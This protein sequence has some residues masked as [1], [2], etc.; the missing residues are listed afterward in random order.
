MKVPPMGELRKTQLHGQT[1]TVRVIEIEQ[2]EQS[3]Q[4]GKWKCMNEATGRPLWRTSRQL[5]PM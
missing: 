4:H 5:K 1:V 2:N 3:K